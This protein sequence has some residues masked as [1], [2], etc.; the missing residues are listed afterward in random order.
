M[1]SVLTASAPTIVPK[2]AA[3]RIATGM[4]THQGSP[5]LISAMPE[6]PKIATM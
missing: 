1:P 3:T 6:A 4:L 2:I 5:M